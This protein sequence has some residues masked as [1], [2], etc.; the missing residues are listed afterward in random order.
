MGHRRVFAAL[1][2]ACSGSM[3]GALASLGKRAYMVRGLLNC[4]EE[5]FSLIWDAGKD[6]DR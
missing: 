4:E 5:G 6:A 1:N 2:G 3:R